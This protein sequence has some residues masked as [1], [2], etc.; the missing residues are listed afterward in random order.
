[1]K[2]LVFPSEFHTKIVCIFTYSMHHTPHPIKEFMTK[3]P[4]TN[5]VYVSANSAYIYCTD[6]LLT[7]NTTTVTPLTMDKKFNKKSNT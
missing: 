5:T 1:M 2:T 6:A 3:L 7:S 4:T